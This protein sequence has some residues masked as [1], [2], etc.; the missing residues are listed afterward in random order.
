MEWNKGQ[1]PIIHVANLAS[2]FLHCALC[3]DLTVFW[4]SAFF[5]FAYYQMSIWSMQSFRWNFAF[6]GMWY[7]I[8]P[9][10]CLLSAKFHYATWHLQNT[11]LQCSLTAWRMDT[12][13]QCYPALWRMEKTTWC[14]IENCISQ[15]WNLHK[16]ISK[17]VLQ[18]T[19][20]FKIWKYVT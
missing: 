9:S 3:N 1:N 17:Q 19:F 12:V 4:Q 13:L 7:C 16:V 15:K 6:L 8:R 18:A 20:G 5:D 11:I 14:R 10:Y 2:A